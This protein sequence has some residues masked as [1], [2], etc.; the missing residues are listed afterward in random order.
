M[1]KFAKIFLFSLLLILSLSRCTKNS[2]KKNSYNHIDTVSHHIDTLP[3]EIKN[4]NLYDIVTQVADHYPPY[5]IQT[6]H[7]PI[8]SNLKITFFTT[9][10]KFAIRQDT[11]SR[12][13][14]TNDFMKNSGSFPIVIFYHDS[15]SMAYFGGGVG[16]Q[17]WYYFLGKQL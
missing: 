13:T 6:T 10:D 1:I 5:S 3:T 14:N 16:T 8:D 15:I 7:D 9:L 11:F 2:S 12:N 17:T 4:Y